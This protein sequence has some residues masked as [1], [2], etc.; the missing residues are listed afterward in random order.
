MRDL[1]EKT[2]KWKSN[3][4]QRTHGLNTDSMPLIQGSTSQKA[5]IYIFSFLVIWLFF[6]AGHHTYIFLLNHILTQ[7]SL[8][9]PAPVFRNQYSKFRM[10]VR[11][12][13]T[14]AF[15]C[16]AYFINS[17]LLTLNELLFQPACYKGQRSR[18]SLLSTCSTPF[19]A[20]ITWIRIP[21][22]TWHEKKIKKSVFSH[23]LSV[24]SLVMSSSVDASWSISVWPSFW[25][26]GSCILSN[27][28]RWEV[29][30]E[31]ETAQLPCPSLW[32]LCPQLLSAFFALCCLLMTSFGSWSRW[33][34]ILTWFIWWQLEERLPLVLSL[35]L[36]RTNVWLLVCCFIVC[37]AA[38]WREVIFCVMSVTTVRLLLY[39]ALEVF[40]CSSIRWFCFKLRLKSPLG[41]P[42]NS[43]TIF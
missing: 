38:V 40:L 13:L 20:D 28:W 10:A 6:V 12:L 36:V 27:R 34:F 31:R 16:L 1:R 25:S 23:S 29:G 43:L 17:T 22:W 14:F 41:L 8:E 9:D 3:G 11:K 30:R 18:G 37:T 5:F 33:I 26:S 35:E 4:K 15:L 32:A 19:G 24:V 39:L 21:D 7:T 2:R 42:W